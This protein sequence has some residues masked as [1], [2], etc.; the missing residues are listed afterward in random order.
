MKINRLSIIIPC[1]NEGKTIEILLRRILDLDLHPTEKEIILVDD[2]SKDGTKEILKKFEIKDK[3][4][5]I[6][7][8]DRNTGKG[9]AIRTALKHATGNYVIVQDADLEYDPNDIKKMVFHTEKN[10]LEILYGS[11]NLKRNQRSSFLFYFGGKFI[12][13]FANFLYNLKLTDEPTCYKLIKTDLMKKM[14]LG[15]TGFDFCPE[16]T[17]KLARLGCNIKEIP[18]SYFPRKISEG[19]KIRYFHGAQAIWILLKY[20]FWK[21]SI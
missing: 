20:K 5:K 14:R 19:K 18:I 10:N 16:V 2:G 6:L 8:H 4:I 1:F 7:F 12:T 13:Q 17:A 11:R 3:N 9:A 15:C 21:P